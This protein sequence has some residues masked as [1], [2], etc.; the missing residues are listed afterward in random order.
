VKKLN[1]KLKVVI[2]PLSEANSESASFTVPF[3]AIR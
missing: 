2:S 1:R 3:Y